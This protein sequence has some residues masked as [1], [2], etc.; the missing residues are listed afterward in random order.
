[1]HLRLSQSC[2]LLSAET[3]SHTIITQP[4]GACGCRSPVGGKRVHIQ[5]IGDVPASS[6]ESGNLF[7]RLD[8]CAICHWRSQMYDS[9]RRSHWQSG[10]GLRASVADDALRF[11]LNKAYEIE[12]IHYQ[13]GAVASFSLWMRPRM[14]LKNKLF[15][16]EVHW[17]VSECVLEVDLGVRSPLT[18]CSMEFPRICAMCTYLVSKERGSI[19]LFNS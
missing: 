14:I 5:W 19:M 10:T 18:I 13:W 7:Q 3:C 17:P 4:V 12:S 9:L 6:R 16:R 11:R 2:R 8:L 15:H 1:M